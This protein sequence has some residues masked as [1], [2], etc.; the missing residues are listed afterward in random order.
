MKEIVFVLLAVFVFVS[1]S[2]DENDIIPTTGQY[3]AYVEDLV[4]CMVLDNRECVKF[5]LYVRGERFNYNR[6]A[7]IRTNGQYPEYTYYIN[8][9]SVA[10]CF[11]DA[12]NFQGTLNGEL[13]YEKENDGMLSE[14]VIVFEYL[15]PIPFV[16][17]NT[18]MDADN[19][20]LLDSY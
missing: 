3:I 19:D 16:L 5:D 20:G 9:L 1:C 2:K 7:T 6:P 10:V 11:S 18:P 12:S 15:M 17:D 4:V 14:G 13:R 8:D